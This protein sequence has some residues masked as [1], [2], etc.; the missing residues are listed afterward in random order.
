MIFNLAD[1]STFNFTGPPT[2]WSLTQ[3]NSVQIS[4]NLGEL[5]TFNLAELFT[6]WLLT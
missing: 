5:L 3:L 6:R 2:E 1:F 4:F